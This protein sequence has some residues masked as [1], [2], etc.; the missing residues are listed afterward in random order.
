MHGTVMAILRPKRSA[1]Q[2]MQSAPKKAPAWKMP[3]QVSWSSFRDHPL[4]RTVSRC[5]K[6]STVAPGL[7]L[8]VGEEGWLSCVS[9]ALFFGAV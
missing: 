7:K 9:L 1:T 4:L 2:E 5:Q 8:K 3:A 6:L